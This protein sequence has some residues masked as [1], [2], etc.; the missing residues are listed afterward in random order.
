MSGSGRQVRCNFDNLL[1]SVQD[2]RNGHE[3]PSSLCWM[4][5]GVFQCCRRHLS[6]LTELSPT[7]CSV[8][9]P[10]L[11]SLSFLLPVRFSL[12]S[13]EFVFWNQLP[14][15]LS[16]SS[17][18]L[19][20]VSQYAKTPFCLVWLYVT[21]DGSEGELIDMVGRA[22]VHAS[23]H[24]PAATQAFCKFIP[25]LLPRAAWG[26]CCESCWST[27]VHNGFASWWSVIA[28]CH[29]SHAQ[30]SCS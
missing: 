9:L 15:P 17:Q 4:C 13:R 24:R 18:N 23:P 11:F 10:L 2:D 25:P 7:S 6:L 3:T 1:A 19:S 28:V 21:P 12:F 27:A 20:A 30:T 26:R 16:K 22:K 29:K 5:L 8:F 14:F